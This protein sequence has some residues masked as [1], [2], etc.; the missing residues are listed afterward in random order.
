MEQNPFVVSE[1][2][3]GSKNHLLQVWDISTDKKTPKWQARNLPNDELDLQIP[4]WDTD[5]C[6]LSANNFCSVTAYGD[7]RE[8]D[9]K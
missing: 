8:Y 2:V 6:Y 3:I 5:L 1:V 4:I 9:L 7:I